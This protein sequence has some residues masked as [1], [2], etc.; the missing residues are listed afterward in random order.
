MR[1]RRFVL[2]CPRSIGAPAS[3]CRPYLRDTSRSPRESRRPQLTRG[4][5]GWTAQP[6][7]YPPSFWGP[8]LGSHKKGVTNGRTNCSN[9]W[10][11]RFYLLPALLFAE[12][13]LK[14]EDAVTRD[15]GR[16]LGLGGWFGLNPKSSDR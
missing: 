14:T 2:R 12:E 3:G 10:N 16:I 4:L 15:F 13:R 5:P 6:F 11:R 7:S 1:P 8:L 9:G